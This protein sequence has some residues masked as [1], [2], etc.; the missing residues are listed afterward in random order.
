MS[1]LTWR[2]MGRFQLNLDA[3]CIGQQYRLNPRTVFYDEPIQTPE[4]VGG[5]FL[6]NGKL[7]Y[8]ITPKDSK[9]QATVFGAVQ[10]LTDTNYEQF[11]HYPA[12]P[13]TVM[14]GGDL[15]F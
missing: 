6:M 5:Y 1:G 4:R 2:F 15:R 14:V 3:E 12:A 9:V 7:S 13:A 11:D 8:R 10:N